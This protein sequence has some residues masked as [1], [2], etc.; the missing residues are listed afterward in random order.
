MYVGFV[1]IGVVGLGAWSWVVSRTI[2]SPIRDLAKA[3]L[4]V[5]RGELA[6][7]VRVG[8]RDEIGQLSH[9]FNVMTEQLRDHE[10]QL[11]C[12]AALAERQRI[13]QELHNSLAQDLALIRLKVAD[14]EH[15]LNRGET[16]SLRQILGEVKKVAG[17][18][19]DNVCQAIQRCSSSALSKRPDE[20]R[21]NG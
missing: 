12:F 6:K 19:Y 14:A 5:G 17:S 4:E 15:E 16:L 13:A 10:E 18:A 3:T 20:E 8:S 1:I 2:V 11:K 21:S 9:F 7:R